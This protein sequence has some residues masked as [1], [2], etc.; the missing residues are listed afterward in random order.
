MASINNN[1]AMISLPRIF[2]KLGINPFPPN[3]TTYLLRILM[4]YGEDRR[5]SALDDADL[6]IRKALNRKF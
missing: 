6:N 4:G 5:L 2:T 1:I 3:Q